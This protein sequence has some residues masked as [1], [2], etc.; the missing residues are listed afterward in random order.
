MKAK[1]NFNLIKAL[2]LSLFVV[3]CFSFMSFAGPEAGGKEIL[4]VCV[5]VDRCPVFYLDDSKEEIIGIGA[6]LLREAA[7][8]AGYELNFVAMKEETLKDALDNEEYDILMPFGS[9]IKSASGQSSIVSD[10]L[11]QTPFTI[12]TEN[13]RNLSDLNKLKVGMLRSLGGVAETV[14]GMYPD[15]E[16]S[17]YDDMDDCVK[18]LRS[19]EVDALLHNSYVWSF[20]L[21][22]PSYEDLSPQTSSIFSMDF[23]AGTRDTDRGRDIIEHLNRG[24]SDLPYTVS[25]GIVLDYTS[26]NLYK[27]DFFDYI[28]KYGAVIL[29]GV[30]LFIAIIIISQQR[31]TAVKLQQ[32][33]KMRELLDHDSLT[34]ALSINGFR[35]KV[36]EILRDNP[37]TKYF[38]SY[39]NIRDFKY[40]NDRYGKEA[41]DELLSFWVKKS[42]EVMGDDEAI[43]RIEGDHVVVFRHAGGNKQLK[44]D[45]NDV[46]NQVRDFFI[47]RNKDNKVRI[48]SGIYVLT[49]ED[50]RNPDV[51]H[52]VDYA[53]VAE[54]KVKENLKESYGFYN[55][56]QWERGMRS[57]DIIEN[58]PIAIGSGEIQVWYQPQVNFETGSITGAE[59]LCRWKHSKLGWI[60]PGEFIPVLE[61]AGLVYDLDCFVWEKVCQDLQRWND[62]GIHRTVSV[63]IS[64]NDIKEQA[65]IPNHFK[66]LITTY[67]LTPDQLHIEITETAYTENSSYIIDTSRRL[68]EYGFEV[69]MDDFGSGYSSLRMLKEIPVDR[70]KLDFR[71]LT[72]NGDPEKGRIIVSYMIRMVNDL[73]LKLISEGV[74]D[75]IQARFLQENGCSDMQGFYFCKPLPVEEFEKFSEESIKELLN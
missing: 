38:L 39:N 70:I 36:V 11:M 71:F 29:L 19:G 40:I 74:E 55:P 45:E 26:R 52:M 56:D 50:Y 14:K 20:V 48:C 59:A 57:A 17:L 69:E 9:A 31:Y 44:Q 37:D 6:D 65:D 21:Q 5:P 16:I 33:Q 62:Q 4:T 54:K 63:N 15:M 32:E 60:S 73:G 42:M 51:D 25:Q 43:G 75:I 8:N 30:L 12:V 47:S 34:G 64:R 18:A 41:G 67:R 2:I 7:D 27:Y 72:A 66:E 35:K 13:N 68:R 3:L 23:R 10:N 24:I 58:L 49:P 1:R 46:I 28:H 61:E 53:R 22:K